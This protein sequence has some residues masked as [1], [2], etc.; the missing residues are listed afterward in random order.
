MSKLVIYELVE[1]IECIR[2]NYTRAVGVYSDQV[3][4]TDEEEKKFVAIVSILEEGL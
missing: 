4:W 1:F 2:R 3:K